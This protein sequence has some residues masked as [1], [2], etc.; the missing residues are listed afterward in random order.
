MVS[1]RKDFIMPLFAG[2]KPAN[3]NL[4]RTSLGRA[5]IFDKYPGAHG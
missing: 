1:I 4:A 2:I 5:R 3:S